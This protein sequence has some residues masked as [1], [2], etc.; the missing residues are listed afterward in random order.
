LADPR[1]RRKGAIKKSVVPEKTNVKEGPGQKKKN[2]M[3]GGMK[4]GIVKKERVFS[5]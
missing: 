4:K 5:R 3:L 1:R 2:R